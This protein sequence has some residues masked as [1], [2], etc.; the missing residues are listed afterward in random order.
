VGPL[1]PDSFKPAV[2]S[3]ATTRSPRETPVRVPEPAAAP[4]AAPIA[5]SGVSID[6]RIYSREDRDVDPPVLISP[7]PPT[8]PGLADNVVN[9]LE[10]VINEVGVVQKAYWVTRTQRLTDATVPSAAKLMKFRPAVKSGKAVQYRLQ[11]TLRS[12]PR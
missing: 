2:T 9:T 5:T 7:M 1:P 8:P 6:P 10:L 4:P 11:I 3:D 12:P